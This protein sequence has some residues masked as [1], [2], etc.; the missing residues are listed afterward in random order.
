MILSQKT[1]EVTT[2]KSVNAI[3]RPNYT[4]YR[5]RAAVRPIYPNAAS[6]RYHLSRLLD[7][8][9]AGATVLGLVASV[10]FSLTLWG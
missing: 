1:K 7:G 4:A 2:M 10:L 5:R 8:A 3:R 9:L 6:A